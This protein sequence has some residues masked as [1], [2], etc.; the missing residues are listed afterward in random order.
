VRVGDPHQPELAELGDDL[1][2]EP[3]LAVE[4]LGHR[5]AGAALIAALALAPAANADAILIGCTDDDGTNCQ[6]IELPVRAIPVT[7]PVGL[8]SGAVNS[9]C[10]TGT[11]RTIPLGGGM[12]L[13]ICEFHEPPGTG[14]NVG[15][16]WLVLNQ[17]GGRS[18][19]G[20]R[21][22][23]FLHFCSPAVD[24]VRAEHAGSVLRVGY[25]QDPC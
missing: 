10:L 14:N 18:S 13:T 21:N 5:A 9:I 8:A 3:L 7:N 19:I 16:D 12:S 6:S 2:R 4:L 11:D 22:T 25:R 23:A 24:L 20:Q 15:F 17:P 1:V